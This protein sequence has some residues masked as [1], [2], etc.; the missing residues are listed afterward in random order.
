MFCNLFSG[1]CC[2]PRQEIN[3]VNV[4]FRVIDNDGCP[5]CGSV[6]QLTMAD[7]EGRY[8][9]AIS[10]KCGMVTFCNVCPGNYLLTQMAAAFGYDVDPRFELEESTDSNF[11]EVTVADNGCIRVGDYALRTFTVRN[12]SLTSTSVEPPN[13]PAI[14]PPVRLNH[15]TIHGTS[16]EACCKVEV[17]FPNG[18]R[19]CSVTNQD[20]SW[21]VNVPQ[22]A[23]IL[24]REV[25]AAL[26][27]DCRP[28]SAASEGVPVTS[29]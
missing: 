21:S 12:P 20:G 14:I 22:G 15:R 29:A 26:C 11:L 23:L 10:D 4:T 7:G 27:C 1:G 17:T 5:V 8:I 28:R 24:N 3:A 16:D 25:T 2:C 13:A 6:F 19:C 18:V 9:H